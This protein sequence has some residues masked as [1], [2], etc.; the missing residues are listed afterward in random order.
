[1]LY[2]DS[3]VTPILD[4]EE[5]VSSLVSTMY[6]ETAM[7]LQ[8]REH[9]VQVE[10]ELEWNQEII[11]GIA[12]VKPIILEA[13]E[14]YQKMIASVGVTADEAAKNRES[15]KQVVR[16]MENLEEGINS[17]IDNVRAIED[18]SDQVNLLSLNAAIEAARA[19]D[20]GRGFAVVADEISKLA[21]QTASLTKEINQ[22]NTDLVNSTESIKEA[23]DGQ[24]HGSAKIDEAAKLLREM[25]L[26][27]QQEMTRAEDALKRVSEKMA[28]NIMGE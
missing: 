7:K 12:E 10:R 11:N 1:M 8:E 28:Q 18:V 13:V 26:K 4:D 14:E 19:G 25:S 27:Q 21:D 24:F 15:S 22:K 23:L 2:L 20:S 17:I 5:N 3:T 6:N 9:Q 16:D